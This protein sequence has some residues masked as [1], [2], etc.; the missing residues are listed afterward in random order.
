MRLGKIDLNIKLSILGNQTGKSFR[1][2]RFNDCYH[3]MYSV[4]DREH[5]GEILCRGTLREC[6]QFVDG[7]IK[8]IEL[9]R[10]C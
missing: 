1:V 4:N 5:C 8:G 6:Y 7:A 3:V 9:L 2:V 10:E